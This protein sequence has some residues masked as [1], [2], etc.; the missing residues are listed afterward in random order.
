ML[1]GEDMIWTVIACVLAVA[2]I[3]VGCRRFR[4]E[5]SLGGALLGIGMIQGGISVAAIVVA[6]QLMHGP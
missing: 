1:G 5:G 6:I 3:E 4:L 2:L